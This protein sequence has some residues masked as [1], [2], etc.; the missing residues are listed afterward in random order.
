MFLS[1]ASVSV[2]IDRQRNGN[3]AVRVITDSEQLRITGSQIGKLRNEGVRVLQPFTVFICVYPIVLKFGMFSSIL[4]M[5]LQTLP[6]M[7]F[8]HLKSTLLRYFLN[9]HQHPGFHFRFVTIILP[10]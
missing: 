3:V 8:V 2:L 7:L 4:V 5:N 9:P 10:T 1:L 6:F